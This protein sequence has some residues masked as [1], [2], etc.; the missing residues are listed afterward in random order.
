[1]DSDSLEPAIDCRGGT[2]VGLL[3]VGFNAPPMD[4]LLVV[5]AAVL[6]VDGGGPMRGRPVT[7]VRDFVL[8]SDVLAVVAGVPVRGV[9]VDEL[10]D[11][12]A[13]FVGDFVGDC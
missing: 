6:D 13:G 5:V 8:E 10:T 3:V 2:E 4:C 7:L 11:D 9:E 12:G 1:M